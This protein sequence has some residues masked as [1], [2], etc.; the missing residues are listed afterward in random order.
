MGGEGQLFDFKLLE[1][2]ELTHF[3]F[4]LEYPQKDQRIVE[5]F[6]TFFLSLKKDSLE[7]LKFP[8][9][10]D[11]TY[12]DISP[13]D[14]SWPNLKKIT[15][16][17]FNISR[18]KTI[19]SNTVQHLLLKDI[20]IPS[21]CEIVIDC[22]NLKELLLNFSGPLFYLFGGIELNRRLSKPFDDHEYFPYTCDPS[23]LR[24]IGLVI[25]VSTDCDIGIA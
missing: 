13:E 21:D 24:K 14:L 20:V 2:C 16:D 3:T 9:K 10:E 15:V 8:V 22:P 23:E 12:I 17:T 25:N 19:K 11:E 7:Y 18:S 1:E 4:D 5:K 6:K